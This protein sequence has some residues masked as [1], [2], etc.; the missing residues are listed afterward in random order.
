MNSGLL[1]KRKDYAPSPVALSPMALFRCTTS[2]LSPP[3]YHAILPVILSER[4]R[5]VRTHL[6]C[7]HDAVVSVRRQYSWGY[8][9]AVKHACLMNESAG[10]LR[11]SVKG[12]MAERA[13]EQLSLLLEGG[14]R[15]DRGGVNAGISFQ[16]REMFRVAAKRGGFGTQGGVGGDER[17]REIWIPS[18]GRKLT[19]IMEYGI[20]DQ[21]PK[22]ALPLWRNSYRANGADMSVQ[23]YPV[24]G[25]SAVQLLV[26]HGWFA[27]WPESVETGTK[28][29]LGQRHAAQTARTQG[30]SAR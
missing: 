12:A 2:P 21:H 7:S 1:A 3:T 6:T 27:I 23:S 9:A 30:D 20:L 24:A 5:L 13:A 4:T 29:V 11:S 17:R 28:M 10:R 22:T 15:N 14:Y 26:H 8:P 16:R 18:F 25:V 19:R